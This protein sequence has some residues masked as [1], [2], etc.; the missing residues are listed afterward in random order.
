MG[1]DDFMFI[2]KKH[3]LI[4]WQTLAWNLTVNMWMRI[5]IHIFKV[6]YHTLGDFINTQVL[7]LKC[8]W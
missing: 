1:I 4:H 6:Q 8:I 5:K 2:L 3:N 7:F